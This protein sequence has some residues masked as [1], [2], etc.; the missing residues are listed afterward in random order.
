M[1][2]PGE[3]RRAPSD[4]GPL[5][6]RDAFVA[7]DRPLTLL[8]MLSRAEHPLLEKQAADAG[9]ANGGPT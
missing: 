2:T 4:V 8:D 9:V 7:P 5:E 3:F 6:P 1:S